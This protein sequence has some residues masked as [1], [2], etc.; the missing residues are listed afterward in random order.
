MVAK[1]MGYRYIDTGAM[2]R[3]VAWKA[4]KAGVSFQSARALRKAAQSARLE[5]KNMRGKLHIFLNQRDVTTAIRT[6]EVSRA[7]NILAAVEGVRRILREQQRRLGRLGG[8][9]ME[10]RDI[11]TVVFPQADGKF[12]LDASPLE[13]A[14]RR[15]RELNAK[16]RRVSLRAIAK[17]IRQRD[18]RDRT[19]RHSPLRVAADATVLDTTKLSPGQVVRRIVGRVRAL[20]RE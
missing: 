2:Y 15:H 17:A 13:R 7:T 10:G 8:V 16:G 11:G 9:V 19:R 3:A 12:F 6:E 18:Q 20:V 5:F 1:K 4:M 14:R